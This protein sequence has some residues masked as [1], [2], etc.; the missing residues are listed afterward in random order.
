MDRKSWHIAVS[1]GKILF[2]LTDGLKTLSHHGND[3]LASA[4]LHMIS[5]LQ[6]CK[7]LGQ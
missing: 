5:R 3:V 1:V 6:P 7:I 2:L 4:D